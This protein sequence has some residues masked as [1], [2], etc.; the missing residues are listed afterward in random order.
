MHIPSTCSNM[1]IN[2]DMLHGPLNQGP[3][4]WDASLCPQH[5]SHVPDMLDA[6]PMASKPPGTTSMLPSH[7][8]PPGLYPHNLCM[9]LAGMMACPNCWAL[10]QG[11]WMPA[12][13]PA[14]C[15][16]LQHTPGGCPPCCVM[17]LHPQQTPHMPNDVPHL[18]HIPSHIAYQ[19]SI[20]Q[21]TWSI[22]IVQLPAVKYF[23]LATSP[24]GLGTSLSPEDLGKMQWGVHPHI[25]NVRCQ[26]G[27]T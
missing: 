9:P 20:T 7:G 22:P 3:P 15:L 8:L 4:P 26:L 2:L 27:I 6:D 1:S 17:F 11:S 13:Q 10:L 12:M 19:P 23:A 14:G 16:K 18:G 24:P 5:A 25:L 21:A